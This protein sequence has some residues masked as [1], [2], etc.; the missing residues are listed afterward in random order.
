M[1][2]GQ[3]NTLVSVR[4]ITKAFSSNRVLK[5][6]DLDLDRSDVLA[7]VGGNGAGKSTLMKIVMGS[8]SLMMERFTFQVNSSRCH[9]RRWLW[10]TVSTWFH[11]NLCFSRT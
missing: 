1:N 5:G 3:N 9:A 11:R 2:E 10:L 7:L 4:S 6:I 8:I